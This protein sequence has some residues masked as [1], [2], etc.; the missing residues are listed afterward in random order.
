MDL[1][2]I[3]V[4]IFVDGELTVGLDRFIEV[5]HDWTA[6]QSMDE[7]LIDVADYRHVP[8][9]PGIVLV[10]HEADYAMDNAGNRYGLLYNRKS[11]V[12]GSNVDRFG[13]AFDAATRACQR[14]EG[15]VDGLKFSQTEFDLFVN[16]RAL[17]PNTPETY[18]ACRP[19]LEAFLRERLGIDQFT[20]VHDDNPRHRFSV[21]ITTSTPFALPTAL[22]T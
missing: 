4:K 12:E 8:A 16:D 5:F 11:G 9:G 10:G 3:N 15:E 20:L 22:Q 6:A 19:E 17:A 1:Q 21:R 13:Q 14:L 7:L 2:H 18:E